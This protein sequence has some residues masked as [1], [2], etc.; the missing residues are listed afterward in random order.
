MRQPTAVAIHNQNT[1]EALSCPSPRERKGGQ[2]ARVLRKGPPGLFSFAF[3]L[4]LSLTSLS[5]AADAMHDRL[6]TQT[7]FNIPAQPLGSSLKQLADQ[8][9]IQILFE[10]QLVSGLKA[11]AVK[12]H[13]TPLQALKTLLKGTGLEFA[14]KDQTIAVRRKSA[15]TTSASGEGQQGSVAGTDQHYGRGGA[16]ES[17]AG[18]LKVAQAEGQNNSSKDA[19]S[20]SKD[21]K[22]ADS[23]TA[24]SGSRQTLEEVVVTAQ[25]RE[26]RLQDVPAAVTAITS[27]KLEKTSAQSFQDY[28]VGQPSVTYYSNGGQTNLIFIR[29]VGTGANIGSASTTGIYVDEMPIA[30][31][32]GG[33]VDLH[34][35][36]LNR[37]EILRGPQGTLYGASSMGGTVRLIMNKPKLD[38]YEGVLRGDISNTAHGSLNYGAD[39]MV[40]APLVQDRL[41]VRL[42]AGYQY[43][44][45]YIDDVRQNTSNINDNRITSLRGQ[46]RWVPIDKA[47]VLFTFTRQDDIYGGKNEAYVGAAYGP[48]QAASPERLNGKQPFRAYSLTINYDFDFATFVSASNYSEKFAIA[49]EDLSSLLPLIGGPAD[50]A[51]GFLAEYRNDVFTQEVRLAS[52]RGGGSIGW[53]G[54]FIPMA[55]FLVLS[56]RWRQKSPNFRTSPSTVRFAP[57]FITRSQ[58]SKT[59]AMT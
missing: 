43:I 55:H 4:A 59:S 16:A 56:V 39:V 34:P 33:T 45:G 22:F 32:I 25:H 7:S 46:I 14:A 3:A 1:G 29:G 30:E 58:G 47:D 11:P 12:A 23:G 51:L 41:A 35:F 53:L 28:L 52:E 54:D 13:E 6:D 8:A 50:G 20:A 26:E 19:Q 57:G 24:E 49:H 48:Y 18:P 5:S 44:D 31:A 9:G 17:T 27:D 38:V 15:T 10:E 2:G 21:K 37:I 42:V 36:D 40:N